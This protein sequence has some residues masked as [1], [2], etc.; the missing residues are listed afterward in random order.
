[1]LECTRIHGAFNSIIPI[2][3]FVSVQ[4]LQEKYDHHP[5]VAEAK[6]EQQ[7]LRHELH[8]YK[9]SCDLEERGRLQLEIL[10]LRNQVQLYLETGTPG[11]M[12]QRRLSLTPAHG[13]QP[14]FSPIKLMSLT[15]VPESIPSCESASSSRHVDSEPPAS[16]VE[17]HAIELLEQERRE[18]DQREQEFI[19]MV[20]ELRDDCEHHMQLAEKWRKE[21]EGEKR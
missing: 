5:E 16:S 9:A 13:V 7:L 17:G 8:R 10:Q 18:W 4:M 21:L 12:K 3:I 11:S 2:P 15:A 20:Q 14:S 19:S 6:A 1:M